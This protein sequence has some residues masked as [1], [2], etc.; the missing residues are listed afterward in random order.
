MIAWR[1]TSRF[2]EC[3][4]STQ[5]RG[6]CDERTFRQ[7]NIFVSCGQMVGVYSEQLKIDWVI[8]VTKV[9]RNIE[10]S[11]TPSFR[12]EPLTGHEQQNSIFSDPVKCC[13]CL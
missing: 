13:F 11:G 4:K 10:K 6:K 3:E 7:Q 8:H 2:D 1:A 5:L 9:K 12:Y